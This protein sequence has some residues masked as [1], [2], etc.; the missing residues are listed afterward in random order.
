MDSNSTYENLLSDVDNVMAQLNAYPHL[1]SATGVR[2]A[3]VT[4]SSG[5]ELR[6]DEPYYMRLDLRLEVTE[7]VST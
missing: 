2:R 7:E 1:D 4:G 3:V 6:V 5:I